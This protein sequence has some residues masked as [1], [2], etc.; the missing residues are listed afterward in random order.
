MSHERKTVGGTSYIE[1]G[2]GEALVL[3]HGVGLNADA[4]EPQIEAFALTHRVIAPDMFGHGGSV[5]APEG[6]TLDDFVQQV[7]RLLDDLSIS[8]ANVV[9][10]SMGGLVAMGLAIAKPQRVK[11]VAVLNSVYERSPEATTLKLKYPS[12]TSRGSI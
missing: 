11:R 9:G 8:S 5:P 12:I 2:A 7:R 6:A 1:R 10:H 4:W 3:I